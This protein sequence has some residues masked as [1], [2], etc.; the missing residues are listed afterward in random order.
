M[1]ENIYGFAFL[2]LAISLIGM[3]LSHYILK[4]V[5]GPLVLGEIF[6]GLILGPSIFGVLYLG[7]DASSKFEDLLN[8]SNKE[9][10]LTSDVI[11]FLAELGV[12]FLLFE[13]GI[14]L[15]LDKFRKQSVES[16]IIALGGIIIPIL[17][18][19][20][21]IYLVQGFV[22]EIIGEDNDVLDVAIL[23]GT[24]LTAT[25]IGISIRI[26]MDLNRIDT[27]AARILIGAAIIDDILAVF[28][29]TLAI[30]YFEEKSSI[31]LSEAV[32]IGISVVGFFIISLI[33]VKVFLPPII[34]SVNKSTDRYLNLITAIS[35]LFLL[36]WLAGILHLAPLIG[37]FVAGMIVNQFDSF[38]DK[39]QEQ[40]PST[41][42][43][44]IPMFFI[45]V[46]LR[47]DIGDILY[48]KAIIFTFLLFSVAVFTKIIGSILG[49]FLAKTDIKDGIVV[50]IGMA[51]RGEVLLIFATTGLALGI[52][53]PMLYSAIVGV[54]I[55]CSVFIPL[56]LR[57][58]LAYFDKKD[59]VPIY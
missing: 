48:L 58:S 25:S 10:I 3:K 18:G 59:E 56:L 52:F 30:T 15:D 17:G 13:I 19:F 55:L 11:A 36:A 38:T 26:F 12:L 35:I 51:A 41:T 33:L 45:A 24:T 43:W 22:P 6:V 4:K 42:H 29:L 49:A 7:E 54:A 31:N 44:I 46:G 2:L 21:L 23:L 40:I 32:E 5:D 20:L 1:V 37:A 8:L 27:K 39:V 47:V 14:E 9:I 57:Y 34:K 16:S 50:G 28:M 53:V